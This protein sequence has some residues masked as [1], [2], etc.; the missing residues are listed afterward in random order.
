MRKGPLLQRWANGATVCQHAKVCGREGLTSSGEYFFMGDQGQ[1]RPRLRVLSEGPNKAPSP[2]ALKQS[3][4]CYSRNQTAQTP[5]SK[6]PAKSIQ[7]QNL[8]R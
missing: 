8:M 4:W 5:L 3:E 6:C 2:T 1:R 7:A